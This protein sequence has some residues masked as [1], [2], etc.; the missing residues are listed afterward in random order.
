MA[1]LFGFGTFCMPEQPEDVA[2]IFAL[3][4]TRQTRVY[5]GL[6]PFRKRNELI[7]AFKVITFA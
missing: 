4:W 5:Q 6:H 3:E 1:G 7:R 2:S